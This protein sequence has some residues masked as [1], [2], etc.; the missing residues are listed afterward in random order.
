M[1]SITNPQVSLRWQYYSDTQKNAWL[2][3]ETGLVLVREYNDSLN[4]SFANHMQLHSARMFYQDYSSE[5]P[6]RGTPARGHKEN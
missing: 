4:L 6:F 1:Y 2:E 3:A 5:T